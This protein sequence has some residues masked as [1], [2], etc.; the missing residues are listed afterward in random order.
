MKRN[1]PLLAYADDVNLFDDIINTINKNAGTLLQ[2]RREVG[3]EINAKKTKV[4]IHT[5]PL[6]CGTKS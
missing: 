6:E 4:Y 3:T 5:S 2:T 1:T